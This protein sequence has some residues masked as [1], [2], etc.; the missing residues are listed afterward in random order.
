MGRKNACEKRLKTKNKKIQFIGSPLADYGDFIVKA[1]LEEKKNVLSAFLEHLFK[2]NKKWNTISLDEIHERSTTLPMLRLLLADSAPDKFL[3]KESI[4]CMGLDFK[5]STDEELSKLLKKKSIATTE[6]E[7]IQHW[8]DTWQQ[9]GEVL[10]TL[11]RQELQQYD[12]AKNL[13]LIDS[14]LQWAYEHRTERLTSGLVEQQRW[15]MK[16]R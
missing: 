8:V 6:Q 15:F 13:P 1:N 3:I 16:L 5:K 9:A 2:N 12:Y 11:K 4:Q 10:K 14:M 7:Q